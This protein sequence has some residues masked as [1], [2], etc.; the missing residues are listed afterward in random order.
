MMAT[1]H[2]FPRDH[3]LWVLVEPK[4]ETAQI[5]P[6]F[7]EIDMQEEEPECNDDQAGDE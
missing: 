7:P 1:I 3:V 6:L 5:I 2:Y 4:D